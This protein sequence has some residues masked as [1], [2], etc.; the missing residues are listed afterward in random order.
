[1]N[2]LPPVSVV[3]YRITGKQLFFTVPHRV[4]EECDLTVA[5]AKKA[6]ENAGPEVAG[7]TVKPWLNSIIEALLRG[8]WHPPVV[9]VDGRVVSQGM[10]PATSVIEGAI[11]SARRAALASSR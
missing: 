6:V 5:T 2:R 10:V 3:V 1:M 4:C 8:G 11:R 9:T 7:L